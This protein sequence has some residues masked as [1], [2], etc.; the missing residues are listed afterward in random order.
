MRQIGLFCILAGLFSFGMITASAQRGNPVP[1]PTPPP[2]GNDQEPIRVFTEEVRLPIVAVDQYGHFDPTVNPGDILIQEDNVPQEIKSV[3]RIP[4]SVLLLLGT[5][6]SPNPA[7]RTSTTR[8]LAIRLLAQLQPTDRVAVMQFSNQVE[9]LQAWTDRRTD[10]VHVLRNK[11]HSGNGSLLAPAI[12]AA[13]AMLR[14]EPEGN[15][16]LVLVCDGVDVPDGR[17]SYQEMMAV[18]KPSS[19]ESAARKA[20]WDAAVKELQAAQVTVHI[21]SY[22]TYARNIYQGKVKESTSIGVIQTPDLPAGAGPNLPGR[23]SAPR[24]GVTINFDPQMRKLRK[25]Y[26]GAM[27]TAE[28]RLGALADETGATVHQP[29]D[30]ENMSTEA[31]AVAREIG[32]QYVVTYLPKRPLS[33]SPVGEYRRIQL[34]S[35]RIGLTVRTRRGYIVTHGQ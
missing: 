34:S 25:A 9:Q 8:D 29:P 19:A 31:E 2:P 16:H 18:L 11:L 17:A 22:A 13:A 6:G 4:A 28:P 10:V 30:A 35:R 3:R 12:K 7:V 26:E 24:M 20:E 27:K 14:F 1:S 32:S 21:I 33:D 15:R 5:G 23:S